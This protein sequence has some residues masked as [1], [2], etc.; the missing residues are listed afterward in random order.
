MVV[1]AVGATLILD[2]VAP[3][4]PNL[5]LFFLVTVASAWFAGPGPGWLSVILS[6]VAVD[7]FFLEPFF[8]FELSARDIPWLIIFVLF[9]IGANTLSLQRRRAEA[10]LRQ[11]QNDLEKHV[12]ER[13]LDLQRTNERLVAATEERIRAENALR[14]SQTELVRVSRVMTVGELTASIAHEINQPLAAVVANGEAALNWVRRSPPALSEVTASV[15]AIVAAGQRAADVISRVRSLVNR[16]L[17]VM[18]AVDINELVGSV[19]ELLQVGF[20]TADVEIAVRLEPGLS[21]VQGDR[22]QLQQLLMNLLNNA[23]EAMADISGRPRILTICTLRGVDGE[24]SILVEDTGQGFARADEQRIFEPFYST[25]E[26]G[27]GMG[28]AICQTIV[29]L[30]GGRL[31]VAARMPHGLS[32]RVDLP[33]QDSHE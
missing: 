20:R 17:P 1:A 3:G 16:R 7:V 23:V 2:V 26:H 15:T 31:G 21:P 19:L 18:A 28:L 4:R 11:V 29:Q 22:I 25:K 13:T 30:H 5:F 24:T 6:T 27:T 9:S 12:R 32:F 10:Q 33:G 14:A 8:V